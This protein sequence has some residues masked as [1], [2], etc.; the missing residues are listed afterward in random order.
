MLI[1][2]ALSIAVAILAYFLLPN[3]G[4]SATQILHRRPPSLRFD[5]KQHTLVEARGD[6]DGSVPTRLVRRWS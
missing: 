2:G 6:R 1:E 4:E 3:W 5:S